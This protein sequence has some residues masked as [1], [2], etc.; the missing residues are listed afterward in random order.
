MFCG[1]C[2]TQIDDTAAFCPHCGAP[3]GTAPRPGTN[4]TA[5]APG[6]TFVARQQ[7]KV[8]VL[9][10]VAV[11]VVIA[12]LLFLFGPFGGRSAEKTVDQFFTAVQESDVSGVMDLLPPDLLKNAMKQEGIDMDDYEEEIENLEQ[13]LE[14]SMSLVGAFVGGDWSLETETLATT[15]VTGDALK[16]LKQEYQDYD[17]KISAAKT[18]S[19]RLA[20]VGGDGK[21]I[22]D[23]TTQVGV[24][25]VGKNW[26]LD[27]NSMGSLF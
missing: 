16:E 3:V 8:P 27:I 6:G 15:D 9:P 23:T 10:V 25:K 5:P 13:Q 18:V 14:S 11:V 2:G 20:L 22:Q 24:V 17:V 1:N 7:K 21:E 12:V 4:S 19:I 26:Y